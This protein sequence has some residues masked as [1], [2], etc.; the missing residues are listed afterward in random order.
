MKKLIKK[1]V[2]ALMTL[3]ALAIAGGSQVSWIFRK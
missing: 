1:I 3:L 2:P